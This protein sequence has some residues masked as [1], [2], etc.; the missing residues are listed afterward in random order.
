MQVSKCSSEIKFT[1][2]FFIRCDLLLTLFYSVKAK[3]SVSALI[4][5]S[6]SANF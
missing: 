1:Y 4:L 3:A 5:D 6:A 2:L